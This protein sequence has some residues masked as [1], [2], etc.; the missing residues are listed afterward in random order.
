MDDELPPGRFLAGQRPL[1]AGLFVLGLLIGGLVTNKYIDPYLNGAQSADRNSLLAQNQG[2]DARS[3][4][5]YRCLIANNV[6]PGSC[7]AAQT[8]AG[9]TGTASQGNALGDSNSWG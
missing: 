6:E 4:Q 9:K 2:L 8:Q 5:L 3:D 7:G 1:L